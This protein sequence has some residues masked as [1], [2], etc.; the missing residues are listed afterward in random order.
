MRTLAVLAFLAVLAACGRDV[1]LPGDFDM[2]GRWTAVHDPYSWALTLRQEGETVRG[3]GELR[4]PTDTLEVD[5]LG[6]WTVS[7]A[8]PPEVDLRF[9]AP[10]FADTHFAGRFVAADTVRGNI[11]AGSGFPPTAI[12]LIRETL[13][14]IEP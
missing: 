9:R 12:T 7:A 13:A 14:P 8:G 10:G 1:V 6:T 2:T 3:T 11:L 5:V 4:V